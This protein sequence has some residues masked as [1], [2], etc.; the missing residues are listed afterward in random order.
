[1]GFTKLDSGIVNSSIWSEPSDTR[2]LW[3]TILAM[4]DENG[5][6]ATSKSGLNRT[7]N[8]ST[9][10]F[11]RALLTLESPD[12]ES[13]TQDN[14]GR[15]IIKVD[16]GWII[17][18]FMKYRARSE[19]IKDQNRK[20]VQKWREIHNV[21]HGNVT[22]TLPSASVSASSSASSD[23]ENEVKEEKEKTWRTDFAIYLK[24]CNDAFD[25]L[26]E[27][28]VWIKERKEFHPALNIRASVRKMFF[29]Y[30]GNEKTKVGWK[31][32]KASRTLDVDWESTIN[33]GL[34]M[35]C[36][37]VWVQRGEIDEEAEFIKTMEQRN[38]KT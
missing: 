25:S 6:V 5:F 23:D 19:I 34:T 27:N 3:V 26:L 8:I 4:S 13:R 31:K 9:E 17:Q 32:K 33:N 36:N 24:Q 12:L 10:S 20:R 35:K 15:R 28:W 29:D 30:W 22:E 14:E 16:G 2:V 7:A 37:Q 18:N 21:M 11:E 1:M 38:A